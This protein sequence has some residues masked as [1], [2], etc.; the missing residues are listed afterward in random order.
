VVFEYYKDHFA[1]TPVAVTNVNIKVIEAEIII[2]KVG[3]AQDFFVELAN[4]TNFD[5]DLSGWLIAG[6]TKS[7]PIPKNT[8]L[9]G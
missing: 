1:E 8:I 3:D 5:V 9:S 2:A 7:L 6:N 4:K